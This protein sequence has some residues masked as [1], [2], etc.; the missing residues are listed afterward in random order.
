MDDYGH[1]FAD[2]E[3]EALEQRY[4]DVYGEAADS[5]KKKAEKYFEDFERK[6][7]EQAA[8][9]QAGK[10]SE[11]DYRNWRIN[12]MAVGKRWTEFANDLAGECASAN[13]AAVSLANGRLSGVFAANH[14]YAAYTIE[15]G[16]GM[17]LNFELYD[18]R[19]VDRLVKSDPRLLP[20][21]QLD[22]P[23]DVR[24]NVQKV[25][26]AV[27]QGILQGE[28][29]GGIADRLQQV[30]DANRE[31]ALRNARTCV[32]GA[33]NA[34]RLDGYR[35]AERI[36]VRMKKEWL[37]TLDDKTRASH[38]LLDGEKVEVGKAFSNGLMYPGD[39]YGPSEEVYNCR[40]TMIAAVD[41][42]DEVEPVYRRDNI[43]GTLVGDMTYSQWYEAKLKAA[44]TL[45]AAESGT[46]GKVA[47]LYSGGMAL[48]IGQQD[49][50]AVMDLVD[51]CESA[52]AQKA[53]ESCQSA[54]RV[55]DAKH[56][57]MAH[58][59]GQDVYFN[60]DQCK[61]GTPI[62][63]PYQTFFHESG[64]AIDNITGR[65]AKNS[66]LGYSPYYN[67]GEFQHTIKKEVSGWISRVDK[68]LRA[69]FQAHAEDYGWL[70]EN[71]FISDF[72]YE[73]YQ[74]TGQI[75]TLPKYTKSYAYRAIEK[76]MYSLAKI[77]VADLCDMME[78]ATGA[79]FRAVAGHGAQYWREHSR[80]DDCGLAKEAFA[81]M[82]SAV[83]AN[84]GSWAT[85]KKH[86]PQSCSVF[87]QMLAGIT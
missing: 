68:Q 84:P 76:E 16:A 28:S 57:G 46:A 72:V 25:Q 87:E 2:G 6:D 36:G 44:R 9:V 83:I 59:T 10:L 27:L 1:A 65:A 8:L 3:I 51:G 47:R 74:S 53:W 24:W 37:A 5:V 32:T 64:H 20:V 69:D 60:L 13:K 18:R 14:N 48:A 66:L 78:G 80:G 40:C 30:T 86:L 31:A 81:E 77:D 61:K 50:D 4:K 63:T 67:D 45:A 11:R 33:E 55:A 17:N 52:D 49:Y 58:C 56:R 23:K 79:K 85:L 19:T 42:V 34:G 21:K 38:R 73:W 7:K 22:V 82:Y 71:G 54:I 15:H 43:D 35:Y 70:H 75:A 39:P 12:Q 41:D 29:I 26:S 62:S